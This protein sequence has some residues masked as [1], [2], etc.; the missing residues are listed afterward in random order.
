MFYANWVMQ[1][2]SLS[3][4]NYLFSCTTQ[5]LVETAQ[6]L[7]SSLFVP[8]IEYNQTPLFAMFFAIQRLLDVLNPHTVHFLYIDLK[9]QL[10]CKRFFHL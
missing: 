10:Y 2:K 6:S 8:E 9:I 1:T 7:Q 4:D 3:L 5:L